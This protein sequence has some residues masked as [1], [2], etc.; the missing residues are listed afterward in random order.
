MLTTQYLIDAAHLERGHGNHT[1]HGSED[2][3]CAT[4]KMQ[5]V[6]TFDDIDQ[7]LTAKDEIM[8]SPTAVAVAIICWQ[9]DEKTHLK[10]GSYSTRHC[11]LGAMITKVISF[12]E[13]PFR[14]RKYASTGRYHEVLLGQWAS[15][16]CEITN[17]AVGG[18]NWLQWTPQ[19][20]QEPA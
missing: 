7:A 3:Y 1:L 20:V 14:Q 6:N 9:S 5:W 18:G 17:Y 19:A 12:D 10:T 15:L 16:P 4:P 13:R 8:A 2:L 11:A